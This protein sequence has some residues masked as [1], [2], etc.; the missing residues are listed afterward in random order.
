MFIVA[1]PPGGGKSSLFAVSDFA[2]HIFNADDR[3]AR[4]NAGSYERI[5]L[6]VRAT[7]NREF[8]GFIDANIRSGTS[9]ALETTL[10]STIT[11][12]QAK[13]A[14]G[15]GF[16]VSMW[17]VA[18]RLRIRSRH[19]EPAERMRAHTTAPVTCD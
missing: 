15:N 12:D 18:F 1:G 2:D 8:E 6:A 11:F 14:K 19:I 17:Y 5:P 7:V 16:R 9:F 4:L 3:A 10:R 13:L